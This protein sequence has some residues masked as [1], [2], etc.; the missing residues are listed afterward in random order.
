MANSEATRTAQGEQ[1]RGG[2]GLEKDDSAASISMWPQ[3][4][5]LLIRCTLKRGSRDLRLTVRPMSTF[6]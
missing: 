3:H 6:N 1:G 2:G 5:H 4:D